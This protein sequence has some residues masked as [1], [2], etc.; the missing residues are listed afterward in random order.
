MAR[1]K[2]KTFLNFDDVAVKRRLI[3]FIGS[4]RGIHK[5]EIAPSRPTRSVRAN[6]F[7]WAAI[8]TPF[9]EFLSDQEPKLFS[10]EDAHDVL[11]RNLLPS[12]L[13]VNPV[14]GEVMAKLIGETR[15]MTTEEFADWIERCRAWLDE[16]CGLVTL[17][18]GEDFAGKEKAVTS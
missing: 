9:A 7:Y 12:R 13:V 4:R 3:S 6:A 11:K 8:A 14:T 16:K 5:V 2:F 10:P 1:E 17:D 18:P 15:T